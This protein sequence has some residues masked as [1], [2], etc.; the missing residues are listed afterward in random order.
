MNCILQ[1]DCLLHNIIDLL[2]CGINRSK[3]ANINQSPNVTICY[4]HHDGVVYL[5]TRQRSV[6]VHMR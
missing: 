6:Y 3:N 5:D 1:N 2:R 4:C